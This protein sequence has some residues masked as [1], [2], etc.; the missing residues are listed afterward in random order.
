MRGEQSVHD[1]NCRV[2]AGDVNVARPSLAGCPHDLRR[3]AA[4]NSTCSKMKFQPA[5]SRGNVCENPFSFQL[6]GDFV[7]ADDLSLHPRQ[8]AL[9]L[10]M[11]KPNVWEDDIGQGDAL[12]PRIAN[13]TSPGFPRIAKVVAKALF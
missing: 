6:S 4:V 1:S 10:R 12:A 3:N 11:R 8:D 9:Q 7:L 5:D 2:H 13:L